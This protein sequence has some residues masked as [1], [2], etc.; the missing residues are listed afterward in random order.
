MQDNGFRCA[1]GVQHP[2]HLIVGIAVVYLQD[3]AGALGQVDVP[4]ERL[5]L[6]A[7][8]VLAGPEVVKPGLPDDA[9]PRMGCERFD[10]LECRLKPPLFGQSRG[11]VGVQGN[12]AQD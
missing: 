4:P 2:E 11:F 9:D 5:L 6:G 3:F 8:P 10:L 1:L 12:P 7:A